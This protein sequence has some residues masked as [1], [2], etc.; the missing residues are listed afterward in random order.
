MFNP[1]QIQ[2][3]VAATHAGIAVQQRLPSCACVESF[4]QTQGREPQEN[5]RFLDTTIERIRIW[6]QGSWVI[7]GGSSAAR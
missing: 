4:L 6:S 2:R 1:H 5:D 3:I 7:V